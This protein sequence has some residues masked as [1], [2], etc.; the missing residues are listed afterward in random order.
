MSTYAADNRSAA[1][2]RRLREA[3]SLSLAQMAEVAR[4]AN[5]QTWARYEAGAKAIDQA[6]WELSLL[7]LG[8][9]PTLATTRKKLGH[10]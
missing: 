5:R 3:H 6:R 2:C 8:E 4:L 7:L 1:E 9:H 10:S